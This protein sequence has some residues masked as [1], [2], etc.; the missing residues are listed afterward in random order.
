MKLTDVSL[1]DGRRCAHLINLLKTGRWD[2]TGAE[3]DELVRVK[4]WVMLLAG[5]MAEQLKS[6]DAPP[7]PPAP[8]PA[9][10]SFKVKAMGPLGSAKPKKKK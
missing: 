7:A 3:I 10:S 1:D 4:Q 6:K 9:A 2:L 8:A 5:A